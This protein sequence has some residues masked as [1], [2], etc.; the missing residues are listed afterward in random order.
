MGRVGAWCRLEVEEDS[1]R[2]PLH[3]ASTPVLVWEGDHDPHTAGRA[4]GGVR[5]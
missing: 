3:S 4:L 2:S 5:G 1:P